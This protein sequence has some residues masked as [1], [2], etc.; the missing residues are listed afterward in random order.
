L[1]DYSRALQL[2]GNSVGAHLGNGSVLLAKK[3]F[4]NALPELQ[5]ATQLKPSVEWQ[6]R[7]SGCSG[8]LSVQVMSGW[9][10]G[11]SWVACWSSGKAFAKVLFGKQDGTVTEVGAHGISVQLQ[12]AA[13]VLQCCGV[14]FLVFVKIAE[15]N[16]RFRIGRIQR[17]RYS[18]LFFRTFEIRRMVE[19]GAETKVTN[20]ESGPGLQFMEFR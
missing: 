17:S 9:T 14:V 2:D 3:D 7:F 18:V 19:S 5:Q 16:V 4:A 12:R 8:V 20:S 6:S 11:F 10:L 15:M 13:V 1:Q